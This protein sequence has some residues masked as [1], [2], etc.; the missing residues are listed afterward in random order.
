MTRL[1]LVSLIGILVGFA[2]A[3]GADS[4][5]PV[6]GT[7]EPATGTVDGGQVEVEPERALVWVDRTGER[8]WP[9]EG[10]CVV[11]SS[12]RAELIARLGE[13]QER[14]VSVSPDGQF[15]A[16]PCDEEGADTDQP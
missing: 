14:L 7:A 11:P 15:I 16:Y 3:C 10:W 1:L 9:T 4:P 5:Q 8:L 13:E 12:Q 6:A 2:A